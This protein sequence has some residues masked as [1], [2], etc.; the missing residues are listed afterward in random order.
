MTFYFGSFFL[1]PESVAS[2]TDD[3]VIPLGPLGLRPK[4]APRFAGASARRETSLLAGRTQ[5]NNIKIF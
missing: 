5:K 1:C 3:I 4:G 2:A